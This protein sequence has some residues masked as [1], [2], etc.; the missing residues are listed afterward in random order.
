MGAPG[1]IKTWKTSTIG[2]MAGAAL[3][4][5]LG[6]Q[7]HR[8]NVAE[9]ARIESVHDT[10]A[11][12]ETVDYAER[13]QHSMQIGDITMIPIIRKHLQELTRELGYDAPPGAVQMAWGQDAKPG[14]HHGFR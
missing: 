4:T 3:F 1:I 13:F 7:M 14:E 10:Y 8:S 6:V 11:Y 12:R 5:A 9:L 2:M